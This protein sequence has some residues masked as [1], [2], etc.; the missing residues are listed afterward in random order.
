MRRDTTLIDHRVTVATSLRQAARGGQRQAVRGGERQA[1]RGKKRRTACGVARR[2]GSRARRRAVSGAAALLAGA[3]LIAGCGGGGPT[4]GS[5][6]SLGSHSSRSDTSTGSARAS[7]GH[8]ASP[9]SQAIAYSACMHQH[10]VPDFPEPQVS[11][12]G[13]EVSVKIA[14]PAG[15]GHNPRFESAQAACRK[16]LPGGEPGQQ[17]ALTPTQQEQYLKAAACIRAHGV[18]NFPDPTFS[19]GGVHIEHRALN[20]H[21]PAFKAAV[22]ACESL[23]PGGVHGGGSGSTSEAAPAPA[24]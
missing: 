16:L 21:S 24:P 1:A 13:S 6:A 18:P 7:E 15:V 17:T 10:G 12:H 23:I 2:A 22:H 8:E 4:N 3:A 11:E 19:G 9:G 5:V 14:V 20:E